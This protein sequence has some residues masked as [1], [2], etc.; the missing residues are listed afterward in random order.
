MEER[1]LDQLILKT[2]ELRS[3]ETPEQFLNLAW[4]LQRNKIM[5]VM[6]LGFPLDDIQDG[7]FYTVTPR[8]AFF[9]NKVGKSITDEDLTELINCIIKPKRAAV[10]SY[11]ENAV[12]SQSADFGSGFNNGVSKLLLELKKNQ[13]RVLIYDSQTK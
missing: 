5:D 9:Y 12:D 7:P 13:I 10:E 3:V 6:L 11:S 2:I 1:F 4:D 8:A